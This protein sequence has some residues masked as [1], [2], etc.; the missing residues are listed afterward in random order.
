MVKGWE[1]WVATRTVRSIPG[2][3]VFEWCAR[4]S[5]S[6]TQVVLEACNHAAR[7]AGFR[8][9]PVVY[10]LQKMHRGL[11]GFHETK[12]VPFSKPRFVRL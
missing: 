4:D 11:E 3:H 8:S 6:F 9:T 1:A 5:L 7:F 10:V 2:G 12:G